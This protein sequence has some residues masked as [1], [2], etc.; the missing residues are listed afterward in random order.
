[1][2]AIFQIDLADRRHEV[3]TLGRFDNAEE[4]RRVGGQEDR[5]ARRRGL[6]YRYVC[7]PVD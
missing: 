2:F 5:A 1:M 7:G 4:A 6:F 3:R